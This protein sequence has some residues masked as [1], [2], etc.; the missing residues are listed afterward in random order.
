[1]PGSQQSQ[2]GK[3]EKG[4][5][6]ALAKVAAATLA[7]RDQAEANHHALLARIAQL[8]ASLQRVERAVHLLASSQR[9]KLCHAQTGG[10][11]G[12]VATG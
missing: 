7:T 10:K 4:R 1:L 2:Q 9:H 11:W 12:P 5:D 3:R 8:D 6:E